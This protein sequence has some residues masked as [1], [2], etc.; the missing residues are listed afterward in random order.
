MADHESPDFRLLDDDADDVPAA[1]TIIPSIHN[2]N[3]SSSTS[4]S[5]SSSSYFSSSPF[6]TRCLSSRATPITVFIIL[7]IV[8]LPLLGALTIF[9]SRGSVDVPPS[10]IPRLNCSISSSTPPTL[11]AV[12]YLPHGTMTL[13]PSRAGLPPTASTL[14]EYGRRISHRIAQLQPDLIIITTPHGLSLVNSTLIYLGSSAE[15]ASGWAENW[16]DYSIQVPMSGG[17]ASALLRFLQEEERR[18]SGNRSRVEGLTANGGA[19]PT[20]LHWGET[21]PLYFILHDWLA[22]YANADTPLPLKS[23]D[24][25]LLPSPPSVLILSQPIRSSLTPSPTIELGRSL[26]RFLSSLPPSTR[27]VLVLSGDLSHRHPWS[28]SLSSEYTPD[29]TLYPPSGSPIAA[30][31]DGAV[32][33]WMTGSSPSTPFTLNESFVQSTLWE[34]VGQGA[35]TCGYGGMLLQQGVMDGQSIRNDSWRTDGRSP[36]VADWELSDFYSSAPSYFGMQTALY[37]NTRC[38]E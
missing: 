24:A 17:N 16:G 35:A 8:F 22:Q 11:V 36:P 6:V 38:L 19:V 30:Q 9:L 7:C 23:L 26:N 28:P 29:P 20:P 14:N 3:D 18:G 37:T 1:I 33:Q 12:A 4:N 2:D 34:M 15:G 5:T 21:V 32:T 25:S 13:D 27:T 10:L 31:F